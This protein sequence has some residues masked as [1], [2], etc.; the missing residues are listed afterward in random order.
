[1]SITC[2]SNPVRS[3]IMKQQA[4]F[5]LIELIAVIVILGILAATA[6]PRFVN[7]SDAAREASLQGVAGAL[8]SAAALNHAANIATD[9]GLTGAPTPTAIATCEAVG[10]L[11]SPALDAQFEIAAGTG[12]TIEG[13]GVGTEGGSST[14]SVSYADANI[15]AAPATFVAY[16]VA[17]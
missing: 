13:S 10:A 8:G 1:M 5:T 12:T 11:L 7:L 9:A 14:C 16:G 3:L 2:L 15:T 4:G 17:N 6:L